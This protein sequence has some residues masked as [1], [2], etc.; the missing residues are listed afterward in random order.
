MWI[1]K[2]LNA[3]TKRS[4]GSSFGEHG[5]EGVLEQPVAI[6]LAWTALQYPGSRTSC[7]A[8]CT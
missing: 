1:Q 4:F 6:A 7:F 8:P 3:Y 5:M 2:G